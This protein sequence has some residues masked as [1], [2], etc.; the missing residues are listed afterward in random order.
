MSFKV[1]IVGVGENAR[2]HARACRDVPA[3]DLVAICDISAAALQR[4]G[5]EFGIQQR[6][7]QLDEMLAQQHLDIVII[8]TWGVHHAEVGQ[9]AARS[10]KVR[11]LLV[12][13]PISATVAEYEQMM[14]VAREHNVLLVE[15]YKWRHDPQHLR[16]KEIVDSGRI[17]MN[18]PYDQ[19]SVRDQEFVDQ[20]DLPSRL[21]VFCDNFNTEVHHF[22]P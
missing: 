19:R 12:E 15:G 16:V 3:A 13:K 21:H 8:S 14:A 9:A 17:Q 11:A 10:G 1:A 18:L 20:E 22:H 4:F 5:D 2:D 7:T 6:F